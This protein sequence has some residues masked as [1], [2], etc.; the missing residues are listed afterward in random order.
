[1][2][3]G[4][5]KRKK[6]AKAMQAQLSQMQA[7]FEKTEVT[8]SS[9]Q[10]LVTVTLTGDYTLKTI[11][12]KPECIDPED[13]DGLQDL[14]KAAYQDAKTKLDAKSSANMQGLPGISNLPFKL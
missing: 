9:S 1:M 7:D 12:I 6:E 4:F 8:G 11:K 3:T 5:S 10:D 13:A 2:G 14:I